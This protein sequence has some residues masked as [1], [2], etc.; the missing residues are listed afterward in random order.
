MQ[1]S[2]SGA[3]AAPASVEGAAH[4]FEAPAV[5]LAK[6]ISA[7]L[8]A[9]EQE[10]EVVAKAYYTTK[11]MI[12]TPCICSRFSVTA[13]SNWSTHITETGCKNAYTVTGLKRGS[14]INVTCST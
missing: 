2:A 7:V 11:V 10:V 14:S 9:A 3:A 13:D 12:K 1:T 5:P 6:E 4:K 8:N